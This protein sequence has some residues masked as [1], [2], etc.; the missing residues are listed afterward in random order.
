MAQPYSKVENVQ[1]LLYA[2][3]N[4]EKQQ[5]LQITTPANTDL[6]IAQLV[7]LC[8]APMHENAGKPKL[9]QLQTVAALPQS[10]FKV[11]SLFGATPN[12]IPLYIRDCEC[13]SEAALKKKYKAEH[14]S[15]RSRIRDAG[16]SGIPFHEPWAKSFAAFLRHHGP[17]SG[18]SYT[19]DKIIPELG[20]VPNNTRWAGKTEQTWNRPNT[21]WANDGD[22]K[23]P[24]G[25]WADRKGISR[26]ICY[27]KHK[28]GW[29]LEEILAGERPQEIAPKSKVPP[30]NHP[31]PPDC[32]E[33]WEA[34]YQQNAKSNTAR[35]WYLLCKSSQELRFLDE[36]K[37]EYWFPDTYEPSIE[38]A[39]RLAALERDYRY[40]SKA[41]DH[42]RRR[43]AQQ[44]GYRIP[45]N[46]PRLIFQR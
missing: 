23:I 11:I 37:E 28:D 36:L 13:L 40:Y 32:K 3:S 44:N 31:W 14:E 10:Q 9:H 27:R 22:E 35:L 7:G 45:L 12:N 5:Q 20:Y 30:F 1:S 38:E 16:K 17:K 18:T 25:V 43:Y 42:G 19:L 8:E 46:D 2:T 4:A 33:M 26:N 39:G 41:F 15:W 34:D 24:L 6:E 21:I 29:S